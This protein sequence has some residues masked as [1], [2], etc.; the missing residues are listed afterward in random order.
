MLKIT[1]CLNGDGGEEKTFAGIEGFGSASWTMVEVIQ[2]PGHLCLDKSFSVSVLAPARLPAL[3]GLPAH[4]HSERGLSSQPLFPPS[5]PAAALPLTL[6]LPLS[7][8]AS[9]P[10]VFTALTGVAWRLKACIL[11]GE[12]PDTGLREDTHFV[13]SLFLLVKDLSAEEG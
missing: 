4:S 12:H 5:A 9:A 3:E 1:S 7:F 10:G 11:L 8:I 6:T 2:R 13:H